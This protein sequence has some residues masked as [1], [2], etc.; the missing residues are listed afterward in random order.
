MDARAIGDGVRRQVLSEAVHSML[1]DSSICTK[2]ADDGDGIYGPAIRDLG[3]TTQGLP[4]HVLGLLTIVH[5]RWLSLLPRQLNPCSVL[6][7]FGS[8]LT[9]CSDI[10]FIGQ[11]LPDTAAR[12]RTW[13][14][15]T[16][17]SVTIPRLTS[18]EYDVFSN[19][20]T[21]HF[22]M[23]VSYIVLLSRSAFDTIDS[24]VHYDISHQITLLNSHRGFTQAC[25]WGLLLQRQATHRVRLQ[26]SRKDLTLRRFP[27]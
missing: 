17:P 27:A 3:V 2:L 19:I 1:E 23:Q 4:L 18:P 9:A 7:I 20:V 12:L 16:S 11:V 21:E 22:R 6:A 10:S 5:L 24:Q 15:V 14:Q 13:T 25:F 26:H 8:A